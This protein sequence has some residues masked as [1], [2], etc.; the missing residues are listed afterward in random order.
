MDQTLSTQSAKLESGRIFRYTEPFD[1]LPSSPEL[2]SARRRNQLIWAF[3]ILGV[4]A[5]C[6]RYFLCFPLWEDESF[7]ASN[8]IDRGYLDLLLKPLHYYQTAPVLFLWLELTVV[9]IFGFSEMTLRLAPFLLSVAALFLFRHLASRLL[10]GT[11]LVLAVAVLAVGYPGVR[12]AA[13]AKPYGSDLFV[14]LVLLSLVVQWWRKPTQSRWLWGLTLI[15]PFAL[16][17]SYPAVFISGA[18]SIFLGL[19]ILTT[20]RH[21]AW[22]PWVIYNLVLLGSLVLLF[23]VL[24]WGQNESMM[25]SMQHFW[26]VSF[27][28][29]TS[30]IDLSKWFLLTHTGESMAYPVGG[31]HGASSITFLFCLAGIVL[32]CRSKKW[33]LLIFCLTPPALQFLV[34]AM[35]QYPYGGHIKFF[36]HLSPLIAVLMALGMAACLGY[37]ARLGKHRLLYHTFRAFIILLA[38]AAFGAIIRDVARPY[39]TKSDLRARAFARWFWFN[40]AYQ[41]EVACTDID[42]GLKLSPQMWTELNWGATYICNKRIYSPPDTWARPPDWDRISHDWPLRCT[43]YRVP[44]HD[45]DSRALDR[46]LKDMAAKYKLVGTE[47]YPFPRSDKREKR[48]VTVDYIDIYKFV[49]K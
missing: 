22:R 8:F 35:R 9:K 48:L 39:K 44:T 10:S 17:L 15:L 26:Q 36:Q 25:A 34:A 29:I 18:I 33:A 38:V 12:Y 13:E 41:G 43:V 19:I 20:R 4:A 27:P 46:W 32:L 23:V 3:L 47:T 7:L 28:P 6:V 5:R 16:G 11:T 2:P 45:F 49:P 1:P 30:P 42:L 21:Q 24:P 14:S 31:E 37:C 40:A